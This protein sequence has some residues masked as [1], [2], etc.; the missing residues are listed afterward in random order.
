MRNCIIYLLLN[1]LTCSSID[2]IP[3]RD[4]PKKKTNDE[5]KQ[6]HLFNYMLHDIIQSF[7]FFQNNEDFFFHESNSLRILSKNNYEVSAIKTIKET[8]SVTITSTIKIMSKRLAV[9]LDLTIL[10][11]SLILVHVLI[12]FCSGSKSMGSTLHFSDFSVV[13]S[14]EKWTRSTIASSM[15]VSPLTTSW[16][17]R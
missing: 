12:F 2:H 15:T 17:D 5:L 7:F 13:D 9:S 16:V 11:N 3:F 14:L 4:I 6:K 8:K 10:K 1:K